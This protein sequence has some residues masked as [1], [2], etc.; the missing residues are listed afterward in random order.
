MTPCFEFSEHIF[1]E[2]SWLPALNLVNTFV[3]NF[4]DSLLLYGR[5]LNETVEMS[6]MKKTIFSN[7]VLLLHTINVLAQPQGFLSHMVF[8]LD[9]RLFE[10]ELFDEKSDVIARQ[11]V[12]VMNI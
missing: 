6:G 2:L 7:E 4:H 1:G 5:A 10:K 9:S 8:L 11:V 3:A 12:S